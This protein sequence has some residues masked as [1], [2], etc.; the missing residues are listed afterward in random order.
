MKAS[1]RFA[2]T[3]VGDPVLARGA[4]AAPAGVTVD[5]A[6]ELGSRAGSG[7]ACLLDAARESFGRWRRGGLIYVPVRACGWAHANVGPAADNGA[8][9]DSR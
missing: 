2:P 1:L 3:S 6:R 5:I 8:V 4:P 7:G 9:D